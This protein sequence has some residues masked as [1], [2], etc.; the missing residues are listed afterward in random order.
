MSAIGQYW[1]ISSD[2]RHD[3]FFCIFATHHCF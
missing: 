2:R 1:L 3:F